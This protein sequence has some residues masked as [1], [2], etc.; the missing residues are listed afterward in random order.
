MLLHELHCVVFSV[1]TEYHPDKHPK[2]PQSKNDLEKGPQR[3]MCS[4]KKNLSRMMN[5]FKDGL[6]DTSTVK[7]VPRISKSC[8]QGVDGLLTGQKAPLPPG[9]CQGCFGNASDRW[10][11]KM[12]TQS[13]KISERSRKISMTRTLT[14]EYDSKKYFNKT[15]YAVYISENYHDN[16]RTTMNED[17]C[18]IQKC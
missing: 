13:T 15:F 9:S 4:P 6:F 11:V 18:L 14:Y 7:K 2:H 16:G 10:E 3:K 12:S 5:G 1:L 8:L 17:V